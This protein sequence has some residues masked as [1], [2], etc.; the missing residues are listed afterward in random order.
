MREPW[1]YFSSAL[2][3]GAFVAAGLLVY[4]LVTRITRQRRH[5]SAAIAW[6]VLIALVPYVG[7]PLFLFFGSRKFVRPSPRALAVDSTPSAGKAPH[8]A[9]GLLAGLGVAK[10]LPAR[11]VTFHHD[12][13]QAI[14]SLIDLIGA[15]R[16][17]IDVC[18]YLLADDEVGT[19]VSD[20]LIAAAG[21]GVRVRLLIDA[22]GSMATPRGVFE[23]IRSSGI[24]VRRF[25]P[26]LHNPMRGR[27]NLRNHR[28][29]A[30][31]DGD[32]LWSGG[33]NLAVEYFYDCNGRKAWRDLSFVLQGGVARQAELQFEQD[34]NLAGGLAVAGS[35]VDA[36]A[37]G[38]D[39][40]PLAQWIP[41]GPDYADDNVYALLISGAYQARQRIVAVTP[42]FVP[43]DALLDAW[44]LA[45]RRGVR[46][47][48]VVP[49]RSNHRLA[50]L[51]RERALRRLAQAGAEV[52][53]A[54]EMIH[55]KAIVVD[56]DLALCGTVNLDG[57]SLFINFEAMTAFY[58]PSE[59]DWL[60]A[61]IGREAEQSALYRAEPPSWWRDVIEGMARSIGFQ[62]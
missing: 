6:V 54:P 52:F 8:W 4:V 9:T 2:A 47:S 34:W 26:L 61:W 44:C 35:P 17:R 28:K 43:D 21:R 14:R 50:D 11:Q 45:S 10:P 15:A 7:L 39:S 36:A 49:H 53:L 57:R 59:I 29:L 3:H 30:V 56:A 51:A 38:A 13:G 22:V 1:S 62:L 16:D 40:G 31:A 5:P 60:A 58:G 46:V 19:K 23:R 33:R 41:S 20:G 27:T 55:A 32:R 37:P 12:G 48:L 24:E 18:T 42:Y 25:M